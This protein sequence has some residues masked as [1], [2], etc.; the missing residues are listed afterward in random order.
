MR[1]NGEMGWRETRKGLTSFR[2]LLLLSHLSTLILVSSS[3]FLPFSVVHSPSN[4]SR[5][6]TLSFLCSLPVCLSVLALYLFHYPSHHHLVSSLRPSSASNTHTPRLA[7]AG[8]YF[9]LSL[10]LLYSPVPRHLLFIGKENLYTSYRSPSY[11][12][13]DLRF[14]GSHLFFFSSSSW[15]FFFLSALHV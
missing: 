12:I 15:S 3:F 6:H 8:F 4:L 2:S 14:R 5:Q 7:H 13:L 10:P 1:R 9:V 11:L